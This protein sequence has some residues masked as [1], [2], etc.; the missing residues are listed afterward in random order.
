M[1]QNLISH[2]LGWSAWILLL[3]PLVLIVRLV[4]K[5]SRW[6]ILRMCLVSIT[7][8]AIVSLWFHYADA[9]AGTEAGAMSGLLGA[10]LAAILEGWVGSVS[11]SFFIATALLFLWCIAALMDAIIASARFY[12]N[13]Q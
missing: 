9:L 4:S 10:K 5:R 8:V 2:Y 12:S 3:I 11:I 7:G 6:S 1:E 13:K